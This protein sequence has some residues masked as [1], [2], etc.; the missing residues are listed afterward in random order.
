MDVPVSVPDAVLGG[1]VE[2]PTPEGPVSLNVPKGS[3]SGSVLRLKGRGAFDARSGKRGDLFAHLVV[4]LPERVD[5][6][7]EALAEEWRRDRPYAP[8]RRA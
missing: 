8:R 5:A 3:N 4:T 7:L 2:A 6:K 1:K